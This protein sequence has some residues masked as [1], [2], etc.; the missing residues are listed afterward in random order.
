M[1][2]PYFL[3]PT[4][5]EKIWGGNRLKTEF[6]YDIPSDHT[7][8]CWAI[9]AHPHGLSTIMNGQYRGWTLDKLY[10]QHRELFG[11]AT[12]DKFP[13]LVKILDANDDLSVQVH[14]DNE[15][16]QKY[17]KEL[18]K[19][20]CW[21]VLKADPGAEMIYGHNAKNKN[22]LQQLVLTKQ[23]DRLL[24]HVPVQAGD[25]L[26]VPSGT[27]HAIGKGIM[28]IEIQ[29]SSDSTYRLYDFDRIDPNTGQLRELHLKHALTVTNVPHV[30]HKLTMIEKQVGNAIVTTLLEGPYFKV[31][32]CQ[33]ND[34]GTSVFNQD[35][36]TYT[37][38]SVIDGKGK[39]AVN[40]Q[41]FLL[42]KGQHFILPSNVRQWKIEGN[43]ECI[44]TQPNNKL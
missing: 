34:Y 40:K 28:V 17:E 24:R 3:L 43:L 41:D 15:Y 20:E 38:V 22:E 27:I 16:A 30:D 2:E 9:S 32:H 19:T 6:N 4:F 26:Y 8:E 10:K 37:L 36:M 44:V 18:G 13:L 35:E 39:L 5:Q 1:Q 25:F 29:Q 21:Y 31:D 33:I 23:W 14:P 42:H 12:T 11:N 7:G